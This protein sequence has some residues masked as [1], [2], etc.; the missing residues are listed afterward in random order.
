MSNLNA[1]IP[2]LLNLKNQFIFAPIKLGYAD[3]KGFVNQRHI[4]FYSTRSTHMGALSLEPL[5]LDASLREIPTQLGIDD[6]AKV[7][8]LRNLN[9]LIHSSGAKVIAHVNH[10][11]RMA[12]P[13]IP[14]N[15]FLSSSDAPCE[16][17]GAAPKRMDRSDMDAVIKLFSQAAVRAEQADFD[18]IEL[19]FGH[20][21]LLA[22]FISPKVNDRTD[23][24]GGSFEQRITFPLEVLT[25]VK[26]AVSIP[27][28]ARISGDEMTAGG[29][30]LDDML[31]F[32]EIL[33]EQGVSAIHVSAGSVCSTPPWFF[34][35]MFIPKG[36]TWD[37]AK[38]IRNH[39][40]IPVIYVGRIQSFEDIDHIKA[41]ST[42]GD[43]TAIGRGL[44]ADPDFIGK[45]LGK[46]PGNLRP[47]LA[48]AEG[49]LGGV[50]SGRGL[51]CLVN[52]E[53]GSETETCEAAEQPKKY[54]V[55]GGG[56]AGMEAASVL[57]SHGHTVDLYEKNSLGG[58]FKLAPLT[59]HKQSMD[60]LVPYYVKELQDKGVHI[61]YKEF[62]AQDDV[63]D[64][65][66]VII[67]S[68]S[69]PAELKIP[70][71]KKYYWA[72]ILKDKPLPEHKKIL[73]IGGGLIGVDIATALIPRNNSITIVKR[74]TDFGEDM[75]M[76]AKTL[77]LKMMDAQGT[78]FSDHTHIKKVDGRTVYA[79][80]NGSPV[81]FDDIDCIIVSAGMRSLNTLA[82]PLKS[83]V[84]VFVIGDAKA[85]GNAQD[86]VKDA[87]ETVKT[88]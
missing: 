47:C 4:A 52:P 12:N 66:G 29:F 49:C 37:M 14:G 78:V 20:G 32:S 86:A 2:N 41:I 59:P 62:T 69:V 77:S 3:G 79:E 24:F 54:A 34:Q 55:I 8:G 26:K 65:D 33:E 13:K 82:E 80:R 75:E 85:V 68:G 56:L 88:L 83:R 61:V 39:V 53:A 36:K 70:G 63:S 81:Q 15:V 84:P 31:V 43:Y 23:A 64:Y 71:L 28:I 46:V 42:E 11:G 74:T 18:I 16:N 38:A 10:P 67:A 48:C 21:Y 1:A 44:I 72:D 51:Q 7:P 76:I 27:V 73:I 60:R 5:Y 40:S 45:Y 50:K 19:Q 17:G 87:F 6:D 57:K 22:Q 9:S 25:A 58:Q 35:H 30:T